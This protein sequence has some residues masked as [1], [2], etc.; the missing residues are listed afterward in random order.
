[1]NAAMTIWLIC[2]ETLNLVICS[3]CGVLLWRHRHE[4]PDH[5]RHIMAVLMFCLVAYYLFLVP[6]TLL[7][8]SYNPHYELMP[9]TLTLI[10][11]LNIT[12]LA[13][14]PIEVMRPNW[15][16]WQWGLVMCLPVLLLMLPD[17]FSVTPFYRKLHSFSELFCY[18]GEPN[19]WLRLLVLGSMFVY[20]G[21]LLYLPFNRSRSSVDNHWVRRYVL[22]CTL[23]SA[24]FMCKMFTV[25]PFFHLGHQ[26][27]AG[28]F[29][30]YYTRYELRERLLPTNDGK[31]VA[32][33][34]MGK[35]DEL[36]N[37]ITAYIDGEQNWRDPELN[38]DM[39]C[40]Q[41]MSN[42]TYVSQAFRQNAST[43]FSEYV[44]RCRIDYAAAQI[45]KGVDDKTLKDIFFDAGFR[46]HS[47]AYRQFL[48]FKGMS[49][50]EYMIRFKDLQ[51]LD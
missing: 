6:F 50:T 27:W 18:A 39:L 45:A 32:C 8:P 40:Q 7:N 37:R 34:S 43:T 49:P 26:L 12:M 41:V 24:L 20:L 21:S 1:M 42:K 2:S 30:F 22:A 29:F 48:H 19:V 51:A 33:Q 25:N 46:T 38:L 23:M 35:L 11:L 13:L 47:T 15:L 9:K 14:Y 17:E 4:V 44:N 5:S 31:E 36:W 16:T 28:I 10:G 3:V